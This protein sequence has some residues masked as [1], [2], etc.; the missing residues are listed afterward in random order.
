MH[1]HRKGA[2]R[3]G[4]SWH[5]LLLL[6]GTGG[7]PNESRRRFFGGW[8]NNAGFEEFAATLPD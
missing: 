6:I 3:Q 2:S 1:H 7:S 8:G 4:A 5:C